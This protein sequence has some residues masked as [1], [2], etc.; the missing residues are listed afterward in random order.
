MERKKKQNPRFTRDDRFLHTCRGGGMIEEKFLSAPADA[1]A[2][3]ER[4]EK[5]AAP[6][7]MTG[8]GW[9]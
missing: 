3:S 4:E 5:A 7:G 2:G 1:L 8:C 6:L 9:L